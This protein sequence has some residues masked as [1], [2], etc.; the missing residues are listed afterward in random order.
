[1]LKK[2][3]ILKKYLSSQVCMM[4][5]KLL[6]SRGI[7]VR[8]VVQE[9]RDLIVVFPHAYHSGFNHGFN[10][11]E[12][13]N[14]G[15][16]R[17][18]EHGK[19]HRMCT[20]SDSDKAI[21]LDMTPFVERFQPETL[22]IWRSGKDQKLHPDDPQ[23]LQEVFQLCLD[24]VEG[25]KEQLPARLLNRLEG[26]GEELEE[27]VSAVV[28]LCRKQLNH[29]KMYRE[30][31]PPLANLINFMEI[32]DWKNGE[33]EQDKENTETVPEAHHG[34]NFCPNITL[35]KTAV[36]NA[37]KR[38][39]QVKK[40][41]SD[42]VKEYLA[43]LPAKTV[44]PTKKKAKLLDLGPRAKMIGFA[45]GITQEELEAKK[46]MKKCYFKHKFGSC[47]KCS[48]CLRPDCG[49]CWACK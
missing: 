39:V 29:F 33:E 27:K 42:V 32:K 35:V 10:I 2:E 9:E 37:K 43:K 4:S 23:E 25:G 40:L 38:K 41:K 36:R 18:V 28:T 1:M 24:V 26:D 46:M 17:W 12:A 21:H 22:P 34:Q 7:T 19:R 13:S 15:T 20:C 45:D 30:V 16:P 14:F 31:L 3:I 49:R 44:E 6:S 48:A 11:A 5:P 47:L 8:K